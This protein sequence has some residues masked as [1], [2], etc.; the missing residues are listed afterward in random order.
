[1]GAQPGMIEQI[2]G[3]LGLHPAPGV[4]ALCALGVFVLFLPRIWS[5]QRGEEALRILKRASQE[6]MAEREQQE[7]LA[8]SKVQGNPNGLWLLARE[9]M[10]Q[11]RSNFA[12]QV[13][14]ELKST[15]KLPLERAGLEAQLAGPEGPR[16]PIHAAVRIQRLLGLG[17]WRRPAACWRRRSGAGRGTKPGPS[18]ACGWRP[19]HLNLKQA[20]KRGLEPYV[21]QI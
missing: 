10:A 18:C 11:G 17:G 12:R 16:D 21:K 4:V 6:R 9:A 14:A 15:G 1:M 5:S 13:L 19:P 3:V 20:M 8:L 2:L 7:Q